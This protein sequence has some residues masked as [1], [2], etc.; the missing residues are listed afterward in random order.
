MR[1]VPLVTDTFGGFGAESLPLA[2][3]IARAWGR[4]VDV[5]PHIAHAVVMSAVSLRLQ[6]SIARLL[7]STAS[8]A[9][10]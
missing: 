6:R 2:L 8:V 3:R 7:S 9:G 1:F 4:R 5:P 10:G